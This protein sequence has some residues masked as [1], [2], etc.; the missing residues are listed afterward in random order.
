MGVPATVPIGYDMYF[1][2]MRSRIG[3][4]ITCGV[5]PSRV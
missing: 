5:V 4:S 3:D 1:T 2:A